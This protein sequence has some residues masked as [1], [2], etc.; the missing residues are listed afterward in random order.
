M[1]E[2]NTELIDSLRS[3]VIETLSRDNAASLPQISAVVDAA[4]IVL[5]FGE[6]DDCG[7]VRCPYKMTEEELEELEQNY[8]AELRAIYCGE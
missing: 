2:N 4:R 6:R 1:S 3:F 5:E 7:G 8:F